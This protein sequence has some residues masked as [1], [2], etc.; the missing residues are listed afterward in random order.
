M[1]ELEE[2]G[3]VECELDKDDDDDDDEQVS[4]CLLRLNK[5]AGC[6]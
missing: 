1:F 4:G 3:V 5:K 2:N 6:N